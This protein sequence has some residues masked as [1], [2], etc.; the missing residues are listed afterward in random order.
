MQSGQ[1]KTLRRGALQPRPERRRLLVR[2]V[3]HEGLVL[4]RP[5][6]VRRRRHRARTSPTAT[7]SGSSRTSDDHVDVRR[8]RL[9]G[10]QEA[11][12][13][14]GQGTGRMPASA[15]MLT[16]EQIQAIVEYERSLVSIERAGDVLGVLLRPGDPRSDPRHHRRAHRRRRAVRQ[17]LPA[18]ATNLGAR[19][20]FLVAIAGLFGWLALMGS[21]WVST[22]SASRA[23]TRR[24][25]RSRSSTQPASP[26]HD[27]IVADGDRTFLQP[28]E[29]PRSARRDAG[30][31]L[32]RRRSRAVGQAGRAALRRHPHANQRAGRSTR[33][34]E[35]PHRWRCFDKGGERAPPS[36]GRACDHVRPSSTGPTTPRAGAAA[37]ITSRHTEPGKATADTRRPTRR[38]HAGLSV[39]MERDLGDRRLPGGRLIFSAR[40][41]SSVYLLLTCCTAATSWSPP[42]AAH[43]LADEEL[44]RVGRGCSRWASTSP[45]SCCSSWPCCS[46]SGASS[47]PRSWLE[48]PA[49]RRQGGALR[50]RHR[51]EQGAARALP[52]A[53]STSWR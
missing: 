34:A 49:Q 37:S 52:G 31:K 35:L 44:E 39:I 14:Q 13:Q 50:V 5:A 20:G 2:P 21:V 32:R 36:L 10:R 29:R 17:R 26:R 1:Y 46:P 4:R 47:P 16:P 25:S 8:D 38:S 6:A 15:S 33:R 40:R 51:A 45:S 27:P 12:A 43:G 48:G 30:A 3:P 28:T 18:A 23:R 24:G 42:T 9:R 41:S 11:T 7:R 53:A 22:A 19:L